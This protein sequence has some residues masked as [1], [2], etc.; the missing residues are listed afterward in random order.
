MIFTLL[1]WFRTQ[2]ALSPGHAYIYYYTVL[3]EM[4]GE[5]HKVIGKIHVHVKCKISGKF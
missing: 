3:E 4:A 1:Q 2:P 5:W